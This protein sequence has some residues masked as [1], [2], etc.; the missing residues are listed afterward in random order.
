MI[1]FTRDEFK[2]LW[3]ALD[4]CHTRPSGAPV[5][6]LMAKIGLMISY[7]CTHE[8]EENAPFSICQK[9]DGVFTRCHKCKH[10]G[11]FYR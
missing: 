9:P 11:E 4:L 2:E 10:C 3:Y 1:S 8:A 5:S 7:C 6:P